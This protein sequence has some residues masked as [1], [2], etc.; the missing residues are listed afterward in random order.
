MATPKIGGKISPKTTLNI[1]VE[2]G[3]CSVFQ[4]GVLAK[5]SIEI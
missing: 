5:C 4:F 2:R 1:Q 3:F